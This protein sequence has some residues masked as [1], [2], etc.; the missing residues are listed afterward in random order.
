MA[1]DWRDAR[2]AMSSDDGRPSEVIIREARG[3]MQWTRTPPTE[4]GMYVVAVPQDPKRRFK[5]HR[6]PEDGDRSDDKRLIWYGPLPSAHWIDK[7]R[8]DE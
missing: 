3:E 5:F 4:P 2:G 6:L 7:T 1:G 8:E